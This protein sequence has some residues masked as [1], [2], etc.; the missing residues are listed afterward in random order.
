MTKRNL[1]PSFVT[2]AR[3]S[4][5]WAASRGFCTI[6]ASSV[7]FVG[8]TF[9]FDVRTFPRSVLFLDGLCLLVFMTVAR[10]GLRLFH[11]WRSRSQTAEER[12]RR[13]AKK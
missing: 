7:L 9:L 4:G 2:T 8:L 12:K 13:R 11:A 6:S 1:V 5:S 10:L 3:V